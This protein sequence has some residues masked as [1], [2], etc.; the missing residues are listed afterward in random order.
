MKAFTML[1]LLLLFTVFSLQA[2][3][4]E[5]S[6]RGK[7]TSGG[8]PVP[9]LHVLLKGT[10]MG[11][12]TDSLGV[13]NIKK[14]PFGRYSLLIS[15]VGYEAK[16]YAVE[17][18]DT[19]PVY[20][21]P[22]VAENTSTLDEVVVTGTLKEVSRLD[23]PVPV[24]VYTSQYFRKNPTPALFEALQLVNGVRP[25]LNC[26]ICN[27]GDIHINGLEGPYT[28]VL[29]DGMPIVSGL[30][31]VYGLNG[32]PN[33]MVERIEIVKG[34]ASTLY[35]SEAVGGLVNVIT[36]TPAKA[37]LVSADVFGTSWRE[38][39][40]D[41]GLK[42]KVR[43]AV[44]LLG[45]NYF[46][47]Q[48]PLDKN[49][50]NFTDMTLQHR[51]SV[52]NKWAFERKENRIA[53]LAGRYVYEDRWG[54]EMQW[55]RGYRGGSE[56]YGESIYTKRLELIGSYQLP[57]HTQKLLLSGSFNRHL[58]NSVYGNVPFLADQ[59]IAYGQL[60]WD[61]KWRKSHD[62]LIGTALRYTYY[63]DNTP[64]T[65]L[66]T[67]SI[68]T[69]Q[70]DKVVLPGLFVQDEI[71]LSKQ[72]RLLL[73]IRYDHHPQHGHIF[74]P[75]FNYKWSPN[76]Q[77]TLRFSVGNGFRV[78]NL[79]TE[80]HAATTGARQVVIQENLKPEKSWNANLN[81]QK[82]ISLGST[83]FSLDGT[84][85]YTYFTNKIT[86]DYQTNV[87]QILYDNLQGYAVSRGFTLNTD[88]VFTFPLKINAGFTLMDVFQMEEDAEGILRKQRQLLTE[89]LSGTFAIS[90][91]F[92]KAGL[93]IDYTGN[94]YGS[95]KLPLLGKYDNRS[96]DSKPYS[97]QNIQIT[98]S[99]SRGIEVYGGVKNLLNFTP[100][101]NAIARS[102]DPFDKKVL[103]DNEGTVM[104]TDEN[105]QALTFDPNYVYAPNQG[106]RLFAGIRYNLFR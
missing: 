51:I 32:I 1:H 37:P 28:M 69:N 33:S 5:G 36:K 26:N 14:I 18:K 38:L 15:G 62:L 6:I 22:V 57:V 63:D 4:Q 81:Y 89:R 52:F 20:L 92:E 77:N 101:A 40:V 80:D 46:N 27:T 78:V 30:S 55:K 82:F 12:T 70:P 95:M 74:T 21:N 48:N 103:F 25:Q 94:L 67:D 34:P 50:D 47:Y 100:P 68:G 87:N 96:P 23:S 99:F 72:S 3:V 49:D 60:T 8:Q 13:Y 104:R 16:T 76:Q 29:I 7:V 31:T 97:L 84:L 71:S 10:T 9:F 79:F 83:V 54:G 44:S 11:T 86:A 64:A 65:R 75:R 39:N 19:Q 41:L 58:Q 98:K 85:F 61:T 43:K 91:V 66:G 42:T 56:V 106:I 73:G 59:R 93:K 102:H 35:G 90:Y 17:I 88:A 53:S 2:Q 45:L 105:P 24:E